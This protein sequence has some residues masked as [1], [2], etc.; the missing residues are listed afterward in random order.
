MTAPSLASFSWRKTSKGVQL[1]DRAGSP[2]GPCHETCASA[3]SQ[4]SARA[5]H[6]AGFTWRGALRPCTLESCARG[7]AAPPPSREQL[8]TRAPQR[9]ADGGGLVVGEGR[10]PLEVPLRD[11]HEMANDAARRPLVHDR[12]EHVLPQDG[13][14]V[15][16][17]VCADGAGHLRTKALTT[18]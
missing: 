16:G 9:E 2:T 5:P 15:T 3:L 18:F 13:T 7:N 14:L 8:C 10:R 11:E 17:G 4:G 6:G 12:P 1:T